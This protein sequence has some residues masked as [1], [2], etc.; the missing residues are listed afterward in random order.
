MAVVL[1]KVAE[2]V[3]W[4]YCLARGVGWNWVV[5]VELRVKVG[6]MASRLARVS[7][8]GTTFLSCPAEAGGCAGRTAI[9]RHVMASTGGQ[10]V[11][12]TQERTGPILQGT[13]LAETPAMLLPA[14]YVV[15]D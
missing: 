12:A 8:Q 5:L 15:G 14:K 9:S 3:A 6:L 11:M 13:R 10:A 1:S 4:R 2:Q 7:A